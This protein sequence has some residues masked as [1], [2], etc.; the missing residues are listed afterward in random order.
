MRLDP[1]K[2]PMHC[3]SV[4]ARYHRSVVAWPSSSPRGKET[5]TDADPSDTIGFTCPRMCVSRRTLLKGSAAMVVAM[6]ATLPSGRGAA[7]EQPRPAC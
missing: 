5:W 6:G 3:T 2:T 7:A 4:R 1:R